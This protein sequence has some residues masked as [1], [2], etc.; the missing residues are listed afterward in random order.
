[1]SFP[2]EADFALIKIGD[3]ATP[4]VFTIACGIQDVTVNAVANTQD[5]FTRDCAKPGSIPV[6]KTKTTGRQ[7]DITGTGLIDKAHITKFQDALG[8][9]GDY[10]VEL[11]QDDGTDN[12]TLLGTFDAAFNL[13]ASNLSIPRE[14]SASAEVTLANHGDWT[15]TAA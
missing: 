11:Y 4:Q 6:R 14:G 1:M 15:W 7:L 12:G 8:V 3:G 9:V 13:T 10:K 5:R 2:V